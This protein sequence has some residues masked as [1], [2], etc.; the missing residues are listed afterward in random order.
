MS[1]TLGV[2]TLAR[3][4][5]PLTLGRARRIL[6]RASAAGLDGVRVDVAVGQPI[7]VLITDLRAAVDGPL[8]GVGDD[9]AIEFQ[10]VG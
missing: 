7:L 9:A 6:A 4:L 3:T 8:A 5:A 1:A 10:E 2:L